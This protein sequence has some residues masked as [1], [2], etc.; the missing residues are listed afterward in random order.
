MTSDGFMNRRTQTRLQTAVILL[1]FL[2]F[3]IQSRPL[4]S[5]Y[6]TNQGLR[7]TAQKHFNEAVFF[8]NM[9]LFLNPNDAYVHYKLAEIYYEKKLYKLAADQLRVAARLN[10]RL[11][12]A[13]VLLGRLYHKTGQFA[14]ALESLERAL[15]LEPLDREIA[16]LIEEIRRQ[17]MFAQIDKAAILYSQNNLEESRSSLR[18]AVALSE[19]S[20]FNLFVIENEDPEHFDIQEQINRLKLISRMDAQRYSVYR[21]IANRLME[22]HDFKQAAEY[23]KKCLRDK[24]HNAAARHNLGV[25]YFE[26]GDIE[27]AIDE[28]RIALS[29]QPQ[30]ADTIYALGRCYEVS[31]LWD[32]ALQ[33][34]QIL[35][36]F[37]AESPFIHLRLAAISR[38][39]GALKAAQRELERAIDHAEALLLQN[40]NSE[41]G[42]LTLREAKARLIIMLEQLKETSEEKTEEK[43]TAEYKPEDARRER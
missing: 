9:A 16:R 39:R 43:D 12:G 40:E 32:E 10:P 33:L 20:F 14:E 18:K 29:F 42:R 11:T 7:L 41:I 31:G 28:L 6:F 13:Y 17:Y 19:E 38:E 5:P 22:N 27:E 1:V 24:P 8:L 35:L 4:L 3:L 25:A 34:Y 37:T 15:D 23:Y 26:T 21:L 30:N 36:P 2:L